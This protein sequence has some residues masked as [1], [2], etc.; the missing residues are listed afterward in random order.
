MYAKLLMAYTTMSLPSS[1]SAIQLPLA[2]F[3]SCCLQFKS[4]ATSDVKRV[5]LS[6]RSS[7][8]CLIAEPEIQMRTLTT[9][10]EF[11]VLA[12]DGLWDLL[13]SQ[14]VIEL[15]RQNLQQNN[16]D[17]QKCAQ[18]L[19]SD[20]LSDHCYILNHAVNI[21]FR[22]SRKYQTLPCSALSAIETLDLCIGVCWA[23]S[24][25]Y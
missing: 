3:Q 15:A 1:T 22:Q 18:Y 25:F 14:R 6:P 11:V 20:V 17:A 16:N 8:F 23:S 4:R 10:D 19:V 5:M 2:C 7:T 12:C 13:P 9:E 24:S 21:Q